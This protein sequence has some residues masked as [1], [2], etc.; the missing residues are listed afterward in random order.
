MSERRGPPDAS[1]ALSRRP[2][3]QGEAAE[4]QKETGV[5]D[6]ELAEVRLAAQRLA[7]GLSLHEGSSEELAAALRQRRDQRYEQVR[8]AMEESRASSSVLLDRRLSDF[9]RGPG[10]DISREL[11]KL[12]QRILELTPGRGGLMRRMLGAVPFARKGEQEV[13][14][15]QSGR[16]QIRAVVDS[17]AASRRQLQQDHQELEQLGVQLATSVQTL[18]RE[19]LQNHVTRGEVQRELARGDLPP[20]RLQVLEQHLLRPL[21]QE[22]VDLSTQL[23]VALQALVAKEDIQETGRQRMEAVT[24]ASR[25]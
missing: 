22:A 11:P 25:W 4:L 17:L 5:S 7:R 18:R 16:T 21:Q 20:A 14:R 9:G 15:L 19:L 6:E 23:Q 12:R 2:D 13:F 1:E 24:R 8:Q 10:A 3:E